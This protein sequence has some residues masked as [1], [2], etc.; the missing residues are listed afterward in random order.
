ME[1]QRKSP[2][3][4]FW[5]IISVRERTRM[6]DQAGGDCIDNLGWALMEGLW[7]P[8]TTTNRKQSSTSSE[9]EAE[10]DVLGKEQT[11]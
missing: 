7:A 4:P 3:T 5:I 10:E 6:G 11:N 1:E 9:E 8:E 2:P